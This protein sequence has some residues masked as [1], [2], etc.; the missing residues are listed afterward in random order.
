MSNQFSTIFTGNEVL[1]QIFT[2][3]EIAI[4][5]NYIRSL[6]IKEIWERNLY[7]LSSEPS[8]YF[9]AIV[10]FEYKNNILLPK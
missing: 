1:S 9:G 6:T 5:S 10:V 8:D 7:A 3:E 4:I 2:D